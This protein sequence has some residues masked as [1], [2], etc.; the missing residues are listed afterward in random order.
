MTDAASG[1]LKLQCIATLDWREIQWANSVRY[2]GVYLMSDKM[3]TCAIENAKKSAPL[4]CEPPAFRNRA[5][6]LNSETNA[7]A[8][9]ITLCTPKF[10]EVRSKT[11][12]N[13]P[14]KVPHA[15]NRT[16]KMC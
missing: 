13:R 7:R 12:E 10:N 8:T 3:F 6:C 15:N 5:R 4:A 16:T 9:T 11:P 2:I 1:D 14:E